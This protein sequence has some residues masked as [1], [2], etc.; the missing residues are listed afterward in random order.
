VAA[1]TASAYE[2]LL[3]RLGA[4]PEAVARTIE[5]AISRRRPKARYPVTA[6]ARLMLAQHALLPDR[7]WDAMVGTAY[8]RPKP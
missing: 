2:G 3:S 7:A 6:S 4:G 8:P 5:K 1:T